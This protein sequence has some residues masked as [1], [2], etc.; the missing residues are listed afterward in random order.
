M[1]QILIA[2]WWGRSFSDNLPMFLL[3]KKLHD[4]NKELE[5]KEKTWQKNLRYITAKE[6]GKK[7]LIKGMISQ[8]M[9]PRS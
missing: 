7:D 1:K 6:C 2:G 8:K 9:Q 5:K 3:F 4:P